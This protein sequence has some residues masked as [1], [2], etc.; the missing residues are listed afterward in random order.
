MELTEKKTYKEFKAELDK[1][2]LV[3]D[4]IFVKNSKRHND[5]A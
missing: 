5:I 1:E 3:A 2:M 4:R